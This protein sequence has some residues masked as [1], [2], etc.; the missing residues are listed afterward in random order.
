MTK[1]VVPQGSNNNLDG[2]TNLETTNNDLV[3]GINNLGGPKDDPGASK[4]N[5]EDSGNNLEGSGNNLE[6]QLI[7]PT[8]TSTVLG[9]LVNPLVNL[10][11]VNTY[12]S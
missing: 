6:G 3:G 1:L 9:N 7:T 8:L 10:E 4:I 5:L 12:Q 11:T 2:A